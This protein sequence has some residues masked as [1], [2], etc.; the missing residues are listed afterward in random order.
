MTKELSVDEQALK[1][2][3][4][5]RLLGAA[6]LTL[7]AIVAL[8]MLLDNEPKQ[9]GQ[10][11]SLDIP[12]PEKISEFT[13][14]TPSAETIAPAPE[15]P[16][17]APDGNAGDTPA[18]PRRSDTPPAKNKLSSNNAATTHPVMVIPPVKSR[19]ERADNK[20]YLLHIGNYSNPAKAAQVAEKL[21]QN[22][23]N[24]SIEKSNNKTRI[25][26]GPFTDRE[27][28]D[29]ARQLLQKQGTRSTLVIA[30]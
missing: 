12:S 25:H 8:P 10:N 11:I 1:R 20:R 16:A 6:A 19:T 27:Q 26:V 15:T 13:P 23:L 4:R 17:A 30:K 18:A 28:A 3:T 22:N 2:K 5:H 9:T 7:I 24:V 29:K 21:K 14:P